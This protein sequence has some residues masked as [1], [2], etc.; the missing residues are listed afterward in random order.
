MAYQQYVLR[1]YS[2]IVFLNSLRCMIASLNY[3]TYGQLNFSF[4]LLFCFFSFLLFSWM[5][6]GGEGS[7]SQKFDKH[8][9]CYMSVTLCIQTMLLSQTDIVEL[10]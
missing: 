9:H 5:G 4:V 3:P 10:I 2:I 8:A 6:W 1:K 7:L